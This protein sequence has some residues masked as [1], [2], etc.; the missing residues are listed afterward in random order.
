[1][2]TTINVAADSKLQDLVN[3]ARMAC[4]ELMAIGRLAEAQDETTDLGG[5]ITRYADLLS[6]ALEEIDNGVSKLKA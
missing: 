1:M 3:D 5:V 6:E 2:Q 4:N